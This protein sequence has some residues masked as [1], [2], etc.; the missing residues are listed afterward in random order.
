MYGTTAKRPIPVN[1]IGSR[2]RDKTINKAK[3]TNDLGPKSQ[4][5][6]PAAMAKELEKA[7]SSAQVYLSPS[8]TTSIRVG[9]S[10]FTPKEI[11]DNIATAASKMIDKIIPQGW[12]NLRSLHVKGPNSSALPLWQADQLWVEDEDVLDDEQAREA[13]L[14]ASQKGKKRKGKESGSATDD[15]KAKKIK[16]LGEAGFSK[17][18]AERRELLRQQKNEAMDHAESAEEPKKLEAAKPSD[19]KKVKIKVKKT[20]TVS[21]AV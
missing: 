2:P 19:E 5:A 6:S 11:A 16:D 15:S 13:K 3:Q 8:V 10:N 7:L 18:M 12:K 1:L 4:T 17:E 21:A 20:V 14:L 9:Y